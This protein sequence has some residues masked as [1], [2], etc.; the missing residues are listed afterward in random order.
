MP[1]TKSATERFTADLHDYI[2]VCFHVQ[3]SRSQTELTRNIDEA[4]RALVRLGDAFNDA[5]DERVQAALDRWG[6]AE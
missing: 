3:E 5:V 6:M 1:E 2:R 4:S